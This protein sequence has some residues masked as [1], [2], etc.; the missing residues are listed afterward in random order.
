MDKRLRKS[1]RKVRL[2]I[3]DVD[4]VL[5]DGRIIYTSKGHSIKQF[6][7]KDGLGI[8]ILKKAGI[9]TILISSKASPI[10]KIR[11]KDMGVEEVYQDVDSKLRIYNR[12]KRKYNLKDEEICF[13]GDDLVDLGVIKRAG[14]GCAPQDACEEIKKSADLVLKSRG[15][16]G[17][18]R[19][20]VELILKSQNKWSYIVKFY[21][22]R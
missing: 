17:A 11:A 9:P 8:N 2:L 14:V 3:L 15:G 5:T 7:V 6:N 18:V 19:E 4:G 12:I 20:L 10:L 21:S 16:E 1:L 13:V 22:E